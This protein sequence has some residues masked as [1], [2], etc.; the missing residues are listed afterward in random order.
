MWPGVFNMH[1]LFSQIRPPCF[2]QSSSASGS[3]EVCHCH[4]HQNRHFWH[5]GPQ[6]SERRLLQEEEAEEASSPGGRDLWYRKR[7][8]Q[9]IFSCNATGSPPP[10]PFG[11]AWVVSHINLCLTSCIFLYPSA[12]VPADRAEEE[13]PESCGRSAPAA[14]QENTSD[15]RLPA[16]HL[17]PVQR[18]FPTQAGFLNVL[19]KQFYQ[20]SAPLFV[21]SWLTRIHF[22]GQSQFFHTQVPL[23]RF[24]W[25]LNASRGSL[26]S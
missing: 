20:Y 19:N 17:L 23:F 6:K 16:L 7:G 13:G 8:K 5:E 25:N 24:T 9:S 2:E 15:E 10:P 12:E 26:E 3:P 4:K 14:H 18:C 1:F 21:L 22:F 11:A